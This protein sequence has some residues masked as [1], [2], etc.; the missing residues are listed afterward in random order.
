MAHEFV[1]RRHRDFAKGLRQDQTGVERELWH[2]LRANRVEGLRFKRQAPMG[3]YVVD[4]VCHEATV[5]VE[6]DGP[7]HVLEAQVERDRIRDAWLESRGYRVLRFSNA[8]VQQNLLGVL[9]VI[10]NVVRSRRP[11]S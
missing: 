8:E 1:P 7:H 9:A 10:E 6:L 3:R 5:I 11:L 4:F 2:Y